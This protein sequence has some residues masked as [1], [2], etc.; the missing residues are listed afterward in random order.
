MIFQVHSGGD[1]LPFP[2]SGWA[3]ALRAIAIG[4]AKEGVTGRRFHQELSE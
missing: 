1:W 3:S 4:G 2:A